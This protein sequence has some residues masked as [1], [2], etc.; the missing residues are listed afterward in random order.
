MP[1]IAP[2]YVAFLDADGGNSAFRDS[3]E[4]GAAVVLSP[5]AAYCYT[6]DRRILETGYAAMCRY[7]DYLTGRARAGLLDYGLGDWYDIGPK[8]PGE[9]QLTSKALTATVTYCR[10]LITLA[11][12]ARLLRKSADARRYGRAGRASPPRAQHQ[13]VRSGDRQLRPRQHDRQR[14][15]ACGGSRAAALS[16][17]R[18]AQTDCRHQSPPQSRDGGRHRIS[19]CRARPDAGGPG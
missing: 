9:S 18:A 13:T 1:A 19:L 14:D 11:A 4:W 7:A 17:G 12:I 16:R 10:V 8:P 3:P 15:A 5:W 2:E 6:G